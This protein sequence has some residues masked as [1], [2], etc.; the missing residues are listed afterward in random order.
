MEVR[1]QNFRCFKDTGRIPIRPITLLVGENSS[2][3]TSFL[4]GLNHMFGLLN[5]DSKDLNSSPFELGSFREIAHWKGGRRGSEKKIIYEYYS[6]RR[7][8]LHGSSIIVTAIWN[9]SPRA[10]LLKLASTLA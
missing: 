4:A 7:R 1:F 5:D 8:L 2:G 9:W 6:N 10:S 3:K